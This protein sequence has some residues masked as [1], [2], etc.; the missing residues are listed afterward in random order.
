M[1]GE[2]PT[3]TYHQA[4]HPS[5]R[6]T[7]LPEGPPCGEHSARIAALE[8]SRKDHSER[9]AKNDAQLSDG[10]VQFSDLRHDLQ[11]VAAALEHLAQ[12]V[13]QVISDRKTQW[14]AEIG[15]AVI[16]WA[17]PILGYAAFWVLQA[18]KAIHP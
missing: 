8:A 17:V 9:I 10:R 6:Q 16:F 1:S 13:E 5:Y 15:K 2:E 3:K 11:G 4:G 18:S 7:P 14:G 12:R